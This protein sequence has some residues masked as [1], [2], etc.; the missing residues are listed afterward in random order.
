[1]AQRQRRDYSRGGCREC[2]RRKIKCDEGKPQCTRCV[3]LNKPC[4]YPLDGEKVARV[5][6]HTMNANPALY[7]VSTKREL[8]FQHFDPTKRRTISKHT[9]ETKI[10]HDEKVNDD[11]SMN[12]TVEES[13]LNNNEGRIKSEATQ[14]GT[15]LPEE[16]RLQETRLEET[17]LQE[18]RLEESTI[19]EVPTKNDLTNND[20]SNSYDPTNNPTTNTNNL[21]NTSFKLPDQKLLTDHRL[22]KKIPHGKEDHVIDRMSPDTAG[23]VSISSTRLL[24]SRGSIQSRGSSE[25]IQSSESIRSREGIQSSESIRSNGLGDKDELNSSNG[26][27]KSSGLNNS[28]GLDNSSGLNSSGLVKSNGLNLQSSLNQSNT[29][30]NVLAPMTNGFS[31]NNLPG[32]TNGTHMS[33]DLSNSTSLTHSND[34]SYPPVVNSTVSCQDSSTSQFSPLDNSLLSLPL[35]PDQYNVHDL[36]ILAHD[37]NNI[38]TDIIDGT[39]VDDHVLQQQFYAYSELPTP[40]KIAEESVPRHVSVNHIKVNTG[41]EKLYLEGFY[42]VFAMRVMPFGAYDEREQKNANPIRDVVLAYAST[43]PFL[44]A[45]VLAQ[46]AKTCYDKNGLERDYDAYC[47]YLSTSLKLLGPALKRNRDKNVRNDLTRNIECILL[48]VLLLTSANAS[49]TTQRWRPHLMGA[50]EII[51]KATSGKMRLLKTLILCKLWF[52]DFEVL[53]GTLLVQGG[54]LQSDAEI[55]Q[56]MTL[57]THEVVVLKEYG[58]ILEDGFNLMCGYAE[59]SLQLFKELIKLMN[60]KRNS[61]NS[62]VADDSLTY[63]GLISGFYTQYQRVFIDRDCVMDAQTV[64]LPE[65][66]R[67]IPNLV[68]VI[69]ANNDKIVV[70][71]MDLLQQAYMLAALITLLTD[72]MGM[73][74][75]APYVQDMTAKLV[76]LIGFLER[77]G[78]RPYQQIE[79]S[80][81]MIQWPMLVA[82][83][84]CINEEQRYLLMKFFRALVDMGLGSAQLALRRILKVWEGEEGDEEDVVPY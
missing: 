64:E 49:T 10:R 34:S 66:G 22:Q 73:P 40:P 48:T 76:G 79:Y 56:I 60:R 19:N 61:G 50:K 42:H 65:H 70:S 43:E 26:L 75:T 37:L 54:T 80:F 30:T 13:T 68:D 18:T 55:D 58:V 69:Y 47:L 15:R 74:H 57:T 5:S 46:G 83:V 72:L 16:T 29:L 44:L 53:A 51:L 7:K 35:L 27:E 39:P 11:R 6:K 45:A 3:R 38:L 20:N 25:S 1:M 2:K 52:I 8:T 17:R 62:F 36:D 32:L 14:E 59:T 9:N 31:Y 41:H 24:P 12:S 67:D 33:T 82:A 4:L 71:W 21:P 63:M 23:N 81:L 77:Y 28:N 78:S 84:N